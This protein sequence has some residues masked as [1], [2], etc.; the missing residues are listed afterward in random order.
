MLFLVLSVGLAAFVNPPTAGD[1]KLLNP[2]GF[3]NGGT[4]VESG[5]RLDDTWKHVDND[6]CS[7]TVLAVGYGG[8]GTTCSFQAFPEGYAAMPKVFKDGFLLAANTD[9]YMGFH[10][11][12]NWQE[13][14]RSPQWS[15]CDASAGTFSEADTSKMC[16]Q[17]CGQCIL[18]TGSSGSHIFI[19]NE[20]G[21]IGAGGITAQ[22]LGFAFGNGAGQGGTNPAPC[23][24]NGVMDPGE[25][26]QTV[27]DG[28]GFQG[29]TYKRVAC[30]VEGD[31]RLGAHGYNAFPL[32]GDNVEL[33]PL[34]YRVG[35]TSMKVRGRDA[36][37]VP[38][39]WKFV[40]RDWINRFLFTGALSGNV[41]D[42][43]PSKTFDVMFRSVNGQD[44]VCTTKWAPVPSAS[45]ASRGL[46]SFPPGCQF[47]DVPAPTTCSP[48]MP[49]NP[50]VAEQVCDGFPQY[51]SNVLICFIIG[52]CTPGKAS[53]QRLIALA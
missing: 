9:I 3:G 20:V 46:I 32:R 34:H 52:R 29:V 7:A 36:S 41:Y 4:W 8:D 39:A 25:C 24:G 33:T 35:I 45:D 19:I 13:N 23:R 44:L 1:V 37:E 47:A 12:D 5:R 15:L 17:G 38:T 49:P 28:E 50:I 22:G 42:Q 31:I 30:P 6:V 53:I 2:A 10:Y 21:D 18:A 43:S 11:H 14:P 51:C 48:P 27:L 26:S 16:A 40:P